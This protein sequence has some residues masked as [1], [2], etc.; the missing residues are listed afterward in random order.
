MS[1]YSGYWETDEF[2]D[3]VARSLIGLYE[4]KIKKS[5]KCPKIVR[6]KWYKV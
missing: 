4:T 3:L 1:E 2:E 5:K 6:F